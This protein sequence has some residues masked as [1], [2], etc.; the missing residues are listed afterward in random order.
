MIEQL[1]QFLQNH[2]LPLGAMGVFLASVAEEVIAPIPSALIMTMSGFL[3]VSGPLSVNSISALVFK[4]AIPAALG[5]TIGSYFV[6]AIARFG[7]KPIIEKWGKYLGLY[8]GD[9]EK[10][11]AKMSGSRKDEF[12]IASARVLPVFPSVVI[13]AFCGIMEMPLMKYFTISFICVF[14]RGIILGILGWQAAGVYQK[15]AE[16]VS[17]IEKG[18]LL[19]TILIIVIF[20]VIKYKGRQKT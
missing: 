16:I 2:I 6:Y 1:V 8:W 3:L 14:F 20:V 17:S 11:Q 9:V 10:L 12:L 5:V 13:S 7:G 19:S 4:V 15:Y 18:I